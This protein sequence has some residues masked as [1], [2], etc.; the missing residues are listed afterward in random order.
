MSFVVLVF[1][2]FFFKGLLVFALERILSVNGKL[3]AHVGSHV[4]EK[5]PQIIVETIVNQIVCLNK[6]YHPEKTLLFTRIWNADFKMRVV[7][8]G[9]TLKYYN[10]HLKP[11][12]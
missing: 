4:D 1:K 3:K 8:L 9:N 12:I 10:P 11:A 5:N 2:G 7:S 6:A